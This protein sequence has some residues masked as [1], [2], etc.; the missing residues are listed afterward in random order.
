MHDITV[1]EL[2]SYACTSES[3]FTSLATNTIFRQ[4]T[5][6]VLMSNL[7]VLISANRQLPRKANKIM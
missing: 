5:S 1:I 7:I 6:A 3:S 4:R 2:N